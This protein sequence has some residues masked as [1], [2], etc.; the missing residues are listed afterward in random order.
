MDNHD[1][2]DLVRSSRR[3]TRNRQREAKASRAHGAWS[4]DQFLQDL[5]RVTA[6]ITDGINADP[7]D[8]ERLKKSRQQVREDE[9]HWGVED[10]DKKNDDGD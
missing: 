2:K 4:R 10:E 1:Q 5:H 6:P 9:V 8:A 3:V 7:K